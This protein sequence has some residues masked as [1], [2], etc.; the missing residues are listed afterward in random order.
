M[1]TARS[2]VLLTVVN[3][4]LYAIGGSVSNLCFSSSC[5]SFAVEAYD[6]AT[7][8]WA[9]KAPVPVTNA[10]VPPYVALRGVG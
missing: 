3:G 10:F 6:P 1:P 5:A 8:S 9:T 7:N 4:R 2:G